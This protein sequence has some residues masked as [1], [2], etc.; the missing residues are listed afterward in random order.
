[1]SS[2]AYGDAVS[3]GVVPAHILKWAEEADQR[4]E[5]AAERLWQIGEEAKARKGSVTYEV[6]SG[7]TP[8]DV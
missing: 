5:E 7:K 4:E 3:E 8:G 6:R 1:M 2:S